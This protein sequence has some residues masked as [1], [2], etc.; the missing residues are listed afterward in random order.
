MKEERRGKTQKYTDEELIEWIKSFDLLND[1]RKDNISKYYTARKRNMHSYFPKGTRERIS[2]EELIEWIKQFN[3]IREMRLANQNR[4]ILCTKR[5]LNEH[6]PKKLKVGRKKALYTDEEKEMLREERKL[7]REAEKAIKRGQK[8]KLKADRK[9]DTATKIYKGKQ[10]QNGN[11]I[12]GR[13]L[14]EK[15]NP[16]KNNKSICAP[17]YSRYMSLKN[18]NKDHNKWN[19]RDEYCN[20]IIRHHEKT[21]E[22]G[23]K[24]DERT[25]KYLSLIG[26]DFIFKDVYDI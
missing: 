24:V 3:T 8:E 18:N 1:M 21:F 5:G 22:I 9:K 15:S 11:I 12:C 16:H 23:I 7:A 4:Y 14:E 6:F 2:N 19:V 25:M 26:Y 17:C 20:T 10:L 13:C